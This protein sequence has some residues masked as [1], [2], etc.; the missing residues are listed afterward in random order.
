[1]A[2]GWDFRVELMAFNRML[3]KDLPFGALT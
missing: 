2:N 3:K 1:L